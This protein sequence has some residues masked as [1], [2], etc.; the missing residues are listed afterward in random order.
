MTYF[1]T[2]HETGADLKESTRKAESQAKIILRYFK[3]WEDI[4]KSPSQLHYELFS[5]STPVTSVR[6]AFSNLTKQGE[7]E[8]T[9]NTVMGSY[10]KLEYCWK[11]K[12]QEGQLTLY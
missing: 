2:T 1:N 3:C 5:R 7:L 12:S 6:R 9:D 8:K 11:L 4:E 10:G